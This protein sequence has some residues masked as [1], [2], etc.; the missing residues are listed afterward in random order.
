[1]LDG[2]SGWMNKVRGRAVAVWKAT[3]LVTATLCIYSTR[4]RIINRAFVLGVSSFLEI[5]VRC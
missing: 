2:G 3:M 5:E 1:M 4:Q